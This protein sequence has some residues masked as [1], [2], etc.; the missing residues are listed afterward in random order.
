MLLTPGCG[1]VKFRA[2]EIDLIPE[3]ETVVAARP[4]RSSDSGHRGDNP[5]QKAGIKLFRRNFL[6]GEL[7]YL[8]N[9]RANLVFGL[10]DQ[11]RVRAR[12]RTCCS[13]GSRGPI[14]PSAT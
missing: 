11:Q 9:Q 12:R 2:G 5:P 7:G 14:A 10:L 1:V 3:H 13:T 8:L 6:P 4:N